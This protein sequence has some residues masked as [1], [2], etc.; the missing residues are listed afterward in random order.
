MLRTSR[1]T[2]ALRTALTVSILG[3][4]AGGLALAAP[5]GSRF[6]PD[7]FQDLTVVTHEGKKLRFYDD[8]IQDKIV[9]IEF[10]YTNCPDVCSLS[11][12][13]LAEV[14]NRLG[15]R[16]GR[17]IFIY[18]IT[19]DPA[20]DTPDVLKAY[21]EAFKAGPGWLFLTG[22]PGDLHSIR[23]KLGERSRNLAEHRSRIVLGNDTTGEWTRTALM[24]NLDLVAETIKDMDPEWRARPRKPATGIANVAPRRL[25]N[26]PGQALFLKACASCHK[27]GMGPHVGPDLEDV[28]ARRDRAWLVR[29][30]MAPDRMRAQKDPLAVKLD[31]EYTGVRMPNLGLSEADAQ[32]LIAY[33]EAQAK[34]LDA[35]AATREPRRDDDHGQQ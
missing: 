13:R 4:F 9:V 11:T 21:A 2:V 23:Y 5:K 32:D 30:M 6:G 26:Q 10:I 29:Y 34:R 8:L 7:Y 24:G 19:L 17:D 28:T 27:I 1:S 12:A 16:V 14:R 15:E 18:S 25:G 33:F 22:E 3:L 35:A 31:A 20:R